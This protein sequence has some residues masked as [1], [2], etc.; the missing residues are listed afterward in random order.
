MSE[1][2]DCWCV[3]IIWVHGE[4]V[5][6]CCY[7]MLILLLNKIIKNTSV[8]LFSVGLFNFVYPEDI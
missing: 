8:G 3:G 1:Y 5:V 7:N 2:Y 6:I 4:Y